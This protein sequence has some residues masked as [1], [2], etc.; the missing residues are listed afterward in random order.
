LPAEKTY[1][2]N[3]P[4]RPK[5]MKKY[6]LDHNGENWFLKEQGK[7]RAKKKF[8]TTLTKQKLYKR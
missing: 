7:D 5:T 2:K 8:F 1:Q 6:D 3:K 4:L